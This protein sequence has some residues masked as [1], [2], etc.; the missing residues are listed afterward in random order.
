[1]TK[2]SSAAPV[3]AAVVGALVATLVIGYFNYHAVLKAMMPVGWAGSTLIVAAQ[4]VLMIPLGLAWYLVAPKQPLQTLW[5]FVW[6]RLMREAA[7]DVLPFS[8]LGGFVIATRAMAVSGV[9]GPTAIGSG[10]V[11]LTVEIVA[12]L[13]YTL[14]GI[15]LLILQLGVRS[16]HDRLIYSILA[17]SLLVAALVAGFIFAQRRGM[18]PL[19]Q[20]ARRVAPSAAAQ[21]AEVG[22]IVKTAY[23][24]PAHLWAG[25]A[26]HVGCWVASAGG[27]WLI[28]WL[29]GHPLSILSVITIESLLFAIKNAAFVVP[30]GIG[31]QEGAYALLGP[32]FG[33]PPEAALALSLLKR[34]RDIIIGL[35]CLLVWQVLEGRRTR[36]MARQPL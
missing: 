24:H 16:G 6:G 2:L 20:L 4:L 12:Q 26:V 14:L 29:I 34:A 31:V 35:P 7:S 36:A 21:S 15:G 23:T 28:L 19:E 5:V 10:V 22:R 33:L 13:I 27:T 18:A 1:M 25:L 11:D 9:S 17:G 30:T 32:I 3:A 8:P